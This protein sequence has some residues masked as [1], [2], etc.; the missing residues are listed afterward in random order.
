VRRK[1][2]GKNLDQ[3]KITK[4]S[5]ILDP[6]VR[7]KEQS[8]YKDIKIAKYGVDFWN[9][10]EFSYL[11]KK[12]LP[13]LTILEIS[14]PSKSPIT[15]ESKSLK[16]YLNTFFD[17]SF[18]SKAEVLLKIHNDLSSVCKCPVVVKFKESYPKIPKSISLLKTKDKFTKPN[19]IYKFNA[20]RSLCPVTNQPDWA[21]I[22]L[23]SDCKMDIAF[24]NEYFFHSEV[25][26]SFM[27]Y[28]SI[29]FL[30]KYKRSIYPIV[31]AF[32]D[33]FFEEGVL[34]LIQ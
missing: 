6:I 33:D 18:K 19:K 23:R 16:I 14:I 4:H 29:K 20:F 30:R 12:G 27:S 17:L 28:V 9:A 10:Y 8:K 11:D 3:S 1:F 13:C 2:L 15:I 7:K 24:L 21:T 34:I 25:L 26:V 5:S 22:Y 32:M 31:F